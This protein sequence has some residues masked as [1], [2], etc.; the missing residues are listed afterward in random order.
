MGREF[1]SD[2][3]PDIGQRPRTDNRGSSG[4]GTDDAGRAGR[5]VPWRLQ[6]AQKI[7]MLER[8]SREE[9]GVNRQPD[10]REPPAREIRG[11]P[12]NSG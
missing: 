12:S 3:E 8:R 2:C 1:D 9:D 7:V 6:L 4:I 11:R 5:A 10:E